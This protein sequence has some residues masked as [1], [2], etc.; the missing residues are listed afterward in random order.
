MVERTTV[1][2]MAPPSL[3]RD[4]IVC[5]DDLAGLDAILR[6]DVL[7]V[8]ATP[9][10]PLWLPALAA[11]VEAGEISLPRTQLDDCTRAA[12]ADW[13]TR[14]LP[15]LP[16]LA[17]LHEELLSLVDLLAGLT[18]A[19]RFMVRLLAAAPNTECGFHV[20]TVPPGAPSFGLVRVYNGPG[21]LY[22]DPSDVTGYADFYRYLSRRERLGR[23]RSEARAAADIATAAA[24]EAEIRGLDAQALFLRNPQALRSTPPA[25]V[26]AFKHLDASE[27]WSERSSRSAWIHCSPMQGP[28]RL[29]VNI[30]AVDRGLRRLRLPGASAPP[31][32]DRAT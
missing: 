20:D 10:P 29:L 7:A 3:R 26:V 18:G 8:I 5:C 6:D 30:T 16:V 31:P 11:A 9:P 21:T 24:A 19:R 2:T 23:E 28:P 4:C 17:P 32:P 12:L 22:P 14:N 1:G 27:H 13:L 25:A 15:P